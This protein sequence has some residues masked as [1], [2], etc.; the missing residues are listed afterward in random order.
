MRG[1]MKSIST[2]LCKKTV[3]L[4]TEAR[5]RE[6]SKFVYPRMS[7]TKAARKIFQPARGVWV[8][9][10]QEILRIEPL[11]SAEIA[12]QST[13]IGNF[14]Y[15]FYNNFTI[16]LH[17][18]PCFYCDLHLRLRLYLRVAIYPFRFSSCKRLK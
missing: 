18:M 16:F 3:L 13:L 9:F 6:V 5:R 17:E 1:F 10:P 11:K 15:C 12:F 14:L 8:C 2:N 4:W 7:E